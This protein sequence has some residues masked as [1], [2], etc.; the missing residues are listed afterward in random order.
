MRIASY[1]DHEANSPMIYISASWLTKSYC[2]LQITS[3]FKYHAHDNINHF[4][5]L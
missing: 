1:T 3:W 5:G 2:Y 4:L